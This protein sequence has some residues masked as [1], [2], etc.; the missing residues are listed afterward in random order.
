MSAPE[1]KMKGRGLLIGLAVVAGVVALSCL[2]GVAVMVRFASSDEGK[3]LMGAAGKSVSVVAKAA[4]AKGTD[5]LKA[6]GCSSAMVLRRSEAAQL[7]SMWSDGGTTLS[8][9]DD[10]TVVLCQLQWLDKAVE[11][12]AV[13]LTYVEAVNPVDGFIVMVQQQGQKGQRCVV[14]YD[15]HGNPLLDKP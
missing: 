4:R 15:A 1:G 2:V 13:A 10:E 8:E 9:Q 3:R 14:R 12:Q 7:V 5:E 6:L 11:C